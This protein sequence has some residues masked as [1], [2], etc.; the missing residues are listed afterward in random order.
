GT[1]TAH[2]IVNNTKQTVTLTQTVAIAGNPGTPSVIIDPITPKPVVGEPNAF[3]FAISVTGAPATAVF[4]W[5]LGDGTVKTRTTADA[6]KYTY[7][8]AGKYTVTVKVFS[9]A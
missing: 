7:E 6:F 1:Y 2:C 4:E 3:T 5:D 9:T 8:K